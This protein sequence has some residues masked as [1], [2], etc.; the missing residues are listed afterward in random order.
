MVCLCTVQLILRGKVKEK[1]NILVIVFLHSQ[2][3]P[4]PFLSSTMEADALLRSPVPPV[5]NKDPGRLSNSGRGLPHLPFPA[6][7][8]PFDEAL[9]DVSAGRLPNQDGADIVARHGA[10]LLEVKTAERRG[11]T[12]T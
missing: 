5:P 1:G 4:N 7:L 3:E 8:V 6:E 2:Q 9:R 12:P 10:Q 11:E